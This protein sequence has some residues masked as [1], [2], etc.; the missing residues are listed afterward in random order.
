[1]IWL[2]CIESNLK[3]LITKLNKLLK[4]LMERRRANTLKPFMIPIENK[5][6][7]HKFKKDFKNVLASNP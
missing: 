6:I 4:E 7:T 3:M 1:M 2:L 5:E